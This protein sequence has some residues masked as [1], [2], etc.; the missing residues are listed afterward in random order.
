MGDTTCLEPPYVTTGFPSVSGF[1]L[2]FGRILEIVCTTRSSTT[3][4]TFHFCILEIFCTTRSSATSGTFSFCI[5]EIVCTT[6]SS[7]TRGT[8]SFCILEIVCTTRSSTTSGTFYFCIEKTLTSRFSLW[9]CHR[10]NEVIT[11][12]SA[13]KSDIS[14]DL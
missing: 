6:R 4:G 5:L 8:F 2:S 11:L 1:I 12:I 9:G 3:S 14:Y 7:A 10:S 13:R